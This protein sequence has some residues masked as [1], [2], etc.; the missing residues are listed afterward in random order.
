MCET[1]KRSKV[2]HVLKSSQSDIIF[3]Q[4]THSFSLDEWE[5]TSYCSFLTNYSAGTAILVSKNFVG[6]VSPVYISDDG[7]LV[8]LD[9]DYFGSQLRV[10]SVY[11]PNIPADRKFFLSRLSNHFS[12]S[13]HNIV[14]GDFNCVDS[15]ELD[16]Y[17]HSETSSSLEGSTGLKNS[18][19]T[20]A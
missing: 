20:L 10:I 19:Q 4:E 6:T 5:G 15:I 17:N 3:Q 1:V 7:R 12:V 11:A 18:S 9:V 8:S 14:G 16:T 13:R 2:L